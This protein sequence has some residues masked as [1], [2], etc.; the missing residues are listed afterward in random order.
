[1]VEIPDTSFWQHRSGANCR[2]G[3]LHGW[4][5]AWEPAVWGA[6]GSASF[7]FGG[8]RIYRSGDR[9]LRVFLPLTLLRGGQAF[10]D[11][12]STALG[13]WDRAVGVEGDF[14]C[15]AFAGP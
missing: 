6:R 3:Y 5:G 10:F 11:S 2:P 7:S 1:M 9:T 15:R 8:L 4:V 14:E 12:W 13:A